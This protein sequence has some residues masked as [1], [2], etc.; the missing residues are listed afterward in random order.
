MPV[1]LGQRPLSKDSILLLIPLREFR[2]ADLILGILK[3]QPKQ[4]PKQPT[5]QPIL[6]AKTYFTARMKSHY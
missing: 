1:E 5:N 3:L 2:E 6:E 4:N